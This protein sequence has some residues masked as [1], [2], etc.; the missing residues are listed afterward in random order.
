LAPKKPFPE[1]LVDKD[2]TLFP[3]GENSWWV[4]MSKN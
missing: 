2:A 1:Y 4:F 3:K